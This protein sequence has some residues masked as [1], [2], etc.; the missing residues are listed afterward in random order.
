M[1]YHSEVYTVVPQVDSPQVLQAQHHS[2]FYLIVYMLCS[3]CT[4]SK[5]YCEVVLIVEYTNKISEKSVTTMVYCYRSTFHIFHLI[6]QN[7]P[8]IF[9]VIYL[10]FF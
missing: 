10:L 3:W 8:N 5:V 4:L 7:D 2:P 9:K 6:Y 1:S